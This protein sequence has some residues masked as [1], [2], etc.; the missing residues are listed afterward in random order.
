[1]KVVLSVASFHDYEATVEAVREIDPSGTF[2]RVENAPVRDLKAKYVVVDGNS[3]VLSNYHDPVLL[4]D[5]PNGASMD[6]VLRQIIGTSYFGELHVGQALIVE[7][8]VEDRKYLVY[9]PTRRVPSN[10]ISDTT[11]AYFAFRAALTEVL[12]L[13]KSTRNKEDYEIV[14]WVLGARGDEDDDRARSLSIKTACKQM[15][16]AILS[17][18]G[19]LCMNAGGLDFVEGHQKELASLSLPSSGQAQAQA[20]APAQAVKN[21]TEEDEDATTESWRSIPVDVKI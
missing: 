6:G 12:L 5:M 14:S 19:P 20:Q 9:A 7:T 2:F 4:Q 15:L 21:E 18:K 3:F 10:D 17:F 8:P 11:N 1:M 13:E 16:A